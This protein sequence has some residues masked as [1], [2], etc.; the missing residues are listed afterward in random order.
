MPFFSFQTGVRKR[1]TVTR[2]ITVHNKNGDEQLETEINT[3][4]K[5]IKKRKK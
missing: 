4:I 5:M 1:M 3:G 2:E